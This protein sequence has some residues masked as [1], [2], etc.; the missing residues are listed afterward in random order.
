MNREQKIPE[1]TG[2]LG[3]DF[4]DELEDDVFE[5]E[6]EDSEV[7]SESLLLKSM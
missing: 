3:H 4:D 1:I 5:S 2:N 7:S 6:N